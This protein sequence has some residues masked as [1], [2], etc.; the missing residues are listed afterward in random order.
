[1]P[2]LG[3]TPAT[4]TRWTASEV[5]ST[6]VIAPPGRSPSS[7]QVRQDGAGARTR[8]SAAASSAVPNFQTDA[9]RRNPER[10]LATLIP[11]R[12]GD[13]CCRREKRLRKSGRGKRT[14]MLLL[15]FFSCARRP[16]DW[17]AAA[18]AASASASDRTLPGRS[19][20]GHRI[21][22]GGLGRMVNSAFGGKLNICGTCSHL[23]TI[24]MVYLVVDNKYNIYVR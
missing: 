24:F 17:Y 6:A 4:V 20:Q 16:H 14:A 12:N 8:P 18:T 7:P 21:K 22:I 13:G 19:R 3:R 23:F 15:G 5:A 2:S 9:S 1:M 10:T 11:G